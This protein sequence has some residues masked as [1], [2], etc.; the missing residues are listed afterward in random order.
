MLFRDL[1]F[2]RRPSG[3][4][5]LRH[6]PLGQID[7]FKHQLAVL[8][9]HRFG[10]KSE[11]LDQLKLGTEDLE[12]TAAEAGAPATSADPIFS[13]SADPKNKPGRK[14]RD[15]LPRQDAVHEPDGTC[16]D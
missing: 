2:S 1:F 13:D 14:L 12:E 11:G 10:T 5:R 8:G 15:H 16:S 7:K 4:T 3:L 6:G 9:R